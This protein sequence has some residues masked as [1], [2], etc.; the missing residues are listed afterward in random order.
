MS[1]PLSRRPS[2]E[3]PVI[4]AGC[5]IPSSASTVGAT[6]A[7]M[8]SPSS[9]APSSGDDE[10]HRVERVGGVRRA[11]LLEHLVGVAVVGGDDAGAAA[12]RAPPRRRSPRHASTVSTAFT[13]AWITP[14]WPTMSALAKLMI[15]KTGR[16]LAPSGDERVGGLARAHLGLL[17]V[18]RDVARGVDELAHLALVRLLLAAVEEVRHVR[19]LLG[20]GDVQL[21]LA[22]A[23]R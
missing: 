22:A 3:R 19:V 23:R 8:P 15:P 4:S 14:V 1:A 9:R 2:S 13:A 17:V 6:S 20:L 18:G 10:R 12:C 7:R 21:R 16:V 11:V 5:S